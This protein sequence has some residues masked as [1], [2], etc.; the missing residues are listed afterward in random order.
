[1]LA[2]KF[3]GSSTCYARDYTE[4][5]VDKH[6]NV[7]TRSGWLSCFVFHFF[8]AQFYLSDTNE[9]SLFYRFFSIVFCRSV[10]IVHKQ[11][12]FGGSF[13]PICIRWCYQIYLP[14]LIFLFSA[15]FHRR[16]QQMASSLF[17]CCC[18]FGNTLARCKY[19][20]SDINV[21]TVNTSNRRKQR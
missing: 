12:S 21:F 4:N 10:Y 20:Y 15:V 3:H 16:L 9:P 18:N 17:V 11:S 2:Q 5:G 6:I 13:A 14:T 1:M 7:Y 8:V 19:L